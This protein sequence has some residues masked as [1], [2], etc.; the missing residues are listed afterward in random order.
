MEY[1]RFEQVCVIRLEPGEDVAE[2][3]RAVAEREQIHLA[4]VQ[5]LGAVD[6]FTVGV[7]DTAGKTYH[8][9]HFQGSYEIVSLTGTVTTMD[10]QVYCHL[11]MS[12]GDDHG[13]V[14]GGHLNQARISATGE[15]VLT[16]LPG[17]VDRRFSEEI[18]LNLFR[19]G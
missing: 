16:V 11:H 15:L 4:A 17:E 6:E 10:G 2:Q 5:G 14:V 3:V 8:A 1:R 13:H 9:N 19:F 12:A 7:F 18:G